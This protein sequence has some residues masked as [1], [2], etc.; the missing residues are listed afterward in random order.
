MN[1]VKALLNETYITLQSIPVN[2]DSVF[3]MASAMMRLKESYQRLEEL[4]EK[5]KEEKVK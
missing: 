4:E 2:G 1:E 5:T 3:K